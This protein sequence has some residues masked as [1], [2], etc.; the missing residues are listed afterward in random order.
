MD[1]MADFEKIEV[2][3]EDL[4]IKYLGFEPK[5]DFETLGYYGD[6]A[7]NNYLTESFEYKSDY[8]ILTLLLLALNDQLHLTANIVNVICRCRRDPHLRAAIHAA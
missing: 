6:E 8:E 2:V 5:Q 4:E 1:I 7:P 3:S